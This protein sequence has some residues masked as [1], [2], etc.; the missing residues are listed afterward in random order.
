[1]FDCS[2]VARIW[3]EE[4]AQ[5]EEKIILRVKHKTITKFLQ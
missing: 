1:M 5:N 4:G 2:G 3:C